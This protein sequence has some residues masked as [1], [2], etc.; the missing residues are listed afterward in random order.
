M[1]STVHSS[2]NG[3]TQA[4]SGA[5]HG[6]GIKTR[7][8]IGFLAGLLLIGGCGGWA[9]MA[10][11]TGAVIA[12]GTLKIEQ[13]LKTI[14]HLDGGIIGSIEVKEGDTVAQDQ[15]MIRL[16][17]T[18]NLAE[19]SIVKSQVV[20]LS[21]RRARLITERDAQDQMVL[22]ELLNSD[23]KSVLAA[24][25]GEQHLLEGN[26]QNRNS[27]K[28]QL[29]L[30]MDQL[31]EEIHGLEAQRKSKT[32]EIALVEAEK[33]KL[34]GLAVKKLIEGSRTYGNERELVRLVGEKGEI[35][36][37]IARAKARLSETRLQIIAI[38]E[39]AR[40]DAQKELS[41][42]EPKI[43]ELNERQAAIEDRLSRTDIRAPIAGIVNELLV[44]TI[45][46]V[47][48]PAQKVITIVPTGAL[49]KVE[50]KLS[51]N[52]IDQVFLGQ[53]AKLRFTSFDQRTSPEMKGEIIYISAATS[54]EE[55]T[56]Q[57]YYVANV[58]V[59][60][61]ELAQL[62]DHKLMPGM[63]VEV[64]ISTESR[65]ALSYLAKPLMDQFVRALREQ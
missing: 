21:A 8:I 33:K 49:L 56:G 15:I 14:Q 58:S 4:T 37:G 65:T 50:A 1:D 3:N 17:D 42:I 31:Q 51:P 48:T 25:R 11:L 44:H 32:D 7:V 35:D 26:R 34:H 47:I 9:A 27:R 10:E 53:R 61:N 57:T 59:S 36:A 52:D 22:S 5:A 39:T 16:D 46:G 60:A 13:N 2:G 19:L 30:G 28:E 29:S 62:G 24:V 23:D 20:E 43:F 6:F 41:E 54:I 63:P 18:Q 12:G 64:F 45:G 40:T 38:D 55:S